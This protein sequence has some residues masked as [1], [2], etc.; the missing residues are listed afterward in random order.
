MGF[1]ADKINGYLDNL[2]NLSDSISDYIPDAKLI[3][4]AILVLGILV[5]LTGF[6]GCA[7]AKKKSPI[8]TVPFML[9]L[10]PLFLI[11]IVFGALAVNRS[12]AK[13]I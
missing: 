8:F 13:K 10:C 9:C 2:K 7:S 11:M 5:I 3:G 6:C 1:G 4:T 12:I